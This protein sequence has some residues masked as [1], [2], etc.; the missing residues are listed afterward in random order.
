VDVESLK[1]GL[2]DIALMMKEIPEPLQERVYDAMLTKLLA[3]AGVFDDKAPKMTPVYTPAPAGNGP[4][5]EKAGGPPPPG[6]RAPLPMT[7]QVRVFMGKTGVTADDLSKIC[8][9][10]DGDIYFVREP[11]PKKIS[12]GQIE[13]ALLLALKNGLLN[14]AFSVDPEAVRSTCQEKG[15]Y[16]RGNFAANFKAN[17]KLFKDVPKPQGEPQA[18]SPDGLNELG[19]LVKQLAAQGQ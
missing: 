3:D 17:S 8:F 11:A 12:R 18:L 7:A 5:P 15:F 14:N 13:W 6:E 9:L 10:M 16:D 19:V 2:K 4:T 1:K